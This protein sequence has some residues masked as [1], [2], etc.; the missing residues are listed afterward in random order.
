M[1]VAMRVVCVAALTI[2]LLPAARLQSQSPASPQ[3]AVQRELG[4]TVFAKQCGKCHDEDGMKK[5]S[6]GST[7]L[8]RLS[9][10]KNPQELLDTRLKTMTAQDRSAVSVYVADLLARFRP[11]APK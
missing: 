6:D 5:L 8:G 4:R 7:L 2:L 10:R 3:V 9:A 1:P 11:P